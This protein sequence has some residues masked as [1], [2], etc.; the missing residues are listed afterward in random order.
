M[1][2]R[3]TK[4]LTSTGGHKV[5]INAYLTGRESN[6]VKAEL[7]KGIMISGAQGEKPS[8]PLVNTIPQ[9]RITLDKLVISFDGKAEGAV[10]AI[11]DLPSEEYDELVK[12]IQTES[13]IFTAAKK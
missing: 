4:E 11:E 5:V 6:D 7:F 12:A 1:E 8:I 13:K 3:E 9:V 2:N 10:D